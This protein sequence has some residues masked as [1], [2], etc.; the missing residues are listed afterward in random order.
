[1]ANYM[2]VTIS[3]RRWE[4]IALA[5]LVHLTSRRVRELYSINMW[6]EI[7]KCCLNPKARQLYL[8]VL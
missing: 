6:R 8:E 4:V 1:M 5:I 7:R 2:G 3:Q